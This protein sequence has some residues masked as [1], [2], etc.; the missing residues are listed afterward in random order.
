MHL[1]LRQDTKECFTHVVQTRWLLSHYSA[2]C[3]IAVVR[4]KNV[5]L[6]GS[7][8][9]LFSVPLIQ[10]LHST[11]ESAPLY[12]SSF[13]QSLQFSVYKH[14]GTRCICELC[15]SIVGWRN[16]TLLFF[17]TLDHVAWHKITFISEILSTSNIR[18]IM[19]A[20]NTT[21]IPVNCFQTT[22]SNVPEDS[23]LHKYSRENTWS[24]STPLKFSVHFPQ[25][26]QANTSVIHPRILPYPHPLTT[27]T[28]LHLSV[29]I[30]GDVRFSLWVIKHH[31]MMTCGGMRHSFPRSEHRHQTEFSVLPHTAAPQPQET[32]PRYTWTG[33]WMDPRVY[34]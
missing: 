19:G 5:L 18:A 23:H 27:H 22:R 17:F 24:H 8:D 32:S 4:N 28:L 10:R 9:M 1:N 21:E 6:E 30:K 15:S 2:K 20:K 33:G 14:S 11:L 13:F 7:Q 12:T 25:F 3:T 29:A 16:R 26:L 34:H 31:V